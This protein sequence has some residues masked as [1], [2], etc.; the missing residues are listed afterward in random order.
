MLCS[1]PFYIY[2][3]ANE[4]LE[5][6]FTITKDETTALAQ[7]I[8]VTSIA[9]I[10]TRDFTSLES[11]LIRSAKFPG[12]IDIQVVNE[13][14]IILS[15]VVTVNDANIDASP[16]YSIPAIK[17]PAEVSLK[18]RSVEDKLIV[19]APIESGSHIGWVKIDRSLLAARQHAAKRIK[20]Y[21]S[22]GAL[23]I[24]TLSLLLMLSMRKPLKMI[25]SAVDFAARLDEKKGEQLPVSHYSVEIEKLFEVLN[26]A[27]LN[28]AEQDTVVNHVLKELKTQK[29]ALDEHCIVTITDVNGNITYANEKLLSS[30]GYKLEELIG[31]SPHILSS[32]YHTKLFYKDMW[33]TISQG[34]IWHGELADVDKQKNRIWMQTTIIPFLDDNG[35][36]YEYVA[37]QSD[38]TVQKEAES[39]LAVKNMS[40]E[41]LTRELEYKVKSRTAELQK[42]ND[43]LS[44]LNNIKSEFVSIVSHELR[45]PL[46]SIKSFAEIL[47]DDFEELDADTRRHYLSIINE[48]SV[49]LGNLINDVLDLQ[50]IDAG[51]TSWHM[52]TTDLKQLAASTLELFSKSYQD[53][54]LSLRLEMD[55]DALVVDIDSDK[56]KQVL[57][58][59]LSNAYKFTDKGRVSLELKKTIQQPT[60]LVVD[61]DETVCQYIEV[62]LQ[63]K[64]VKVMSCTHAKQALEIIRDKSHQVDLLITDIVMPE[65]DGIQL[66]DSIRSSDKKLPIIVMS[67]SNDDAVLKSLLDYNIATFL[68][69]PLRPA[70]ISRAVEKVFGD[71]KNASQDKQMIEISVTDSGLGIP[72]NELGKVFERFHQVDNF[73]TR[74][75]GGSGLGLCICQDIIEHHGGRLWVTSTLGEGSRF[76]FTLPLPDSVNKQNVL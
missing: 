65:M 60:A 36:P 62:L 51:K 50:K 29:Q 11:L 76:A 17:V 75:K 56:I 12:V 39:M 58:N 32:G 47:E 37:I 26:R 38:I 55:D 14:G 10:V 45:T 49:R 8:A 63:D 66:I 28:L 33:N 70:N 35:K 1:I 4:E 64:G 40:L 27:S 13:A 54:G 23:L 30:T 53:K 9:H 43:E 25:G 71:I 18:L 19:W 46:T 20:D 6:I 16:R 73:E 22:D 52:E 74:E 48:E 3:E 24:L 68:E 34:R 67:S 21:L 7:N 59:L 2:L 42:A 69:K 41:I 61:D 57:S 31:K 44:H 15:D 5:F 72:E